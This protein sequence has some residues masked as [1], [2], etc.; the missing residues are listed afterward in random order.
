VKSRSKSICLVV[1]QGFKSNLTVLDGRGGGYAEG[2]GG[3]FGAGGPA[4][5]PRRSVA[6]GS[7]DGDMDDDIPF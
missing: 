4:P 6:A 7:R 2:A 1:L 3:D 5:T